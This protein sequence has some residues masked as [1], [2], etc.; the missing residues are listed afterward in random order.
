MN[1]YLRCSHIDQLSHMKRV[2]TNSNLLINQSFDGATP[3]NLD[4][5][6]PSISRK[7]YICY[8]KICLTFDSACSY[9]ILRSSM[10]RIMVCMAIKIFWKTN[11]MKPRLS[12]SVYPEPW[13]MRICLIKVDLPDSPVPGIEKGKC[14]FFKKCTNVSSQVLY[15]ACF[16]VII[17]PIYRYESTSVRTYELLNLSFVV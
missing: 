5:D 13:M 9:W 2:V 8:F 15:F 3:F 14:F 10:A 16:L 11:L 12:S 17:F 7:K 4:A 6:L 1:I